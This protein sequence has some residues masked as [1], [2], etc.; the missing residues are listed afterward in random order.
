MREWHTIRGIVEVKR[1]EKV[2]RREIYENIIGTLIGIAMLAAVFAI[3]IAFFFGGKTSGTEVSQPVKAASAKSDTSSK[4]DISIFNK[5]SPIHRSWKSEPAGD[6]NLWLRM[7]DVGKPYDDEESDADDVSDN[8]DYSE[9]AENTAD[10]PVLEKFD[11]YRVSVKARSDRYRRFKSKEFFIPAD[12]L[13][14]IDYTQANVYTIY[15]PEESSVYSKNMYLCVVAP[16]DCEYIRAG[17]QTVT[18]QNCEMYI[19]KAGI[20]KFSVC[21]FEADRDT[22]IYANGYIKMYDT[23][24][25]VHNLIPDRYG[26]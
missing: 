9:S 17:G 19:K 11:G 5:N 23:K 22:D 14:N 8:S 15:K 20:L 24:G 1:E 25:D 10:T 2:M 12:Y 16:S 21:V 6:M 13:A 4:K 18:A 7:T 3:I 26:A